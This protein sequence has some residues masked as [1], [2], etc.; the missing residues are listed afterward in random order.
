[1]ASIRNLLPVTSEILT[2]PKWKCLN[3]FKVQEDLRNRW[4]DWKIAYQWALDN[5][6]DHTNKSLVFSAGHSHSGT[7]LGGEF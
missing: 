1:M 2:S 7:F 5:L 3:Q 4:T 6:M